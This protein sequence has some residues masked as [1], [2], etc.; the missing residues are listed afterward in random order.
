LKHLKAGKSHW[1]VNQHLITNA[2]VSGQFFYLNTGLPQ[3]K[4][5][6]AAKATEY[7]DAKSGREQMEL[8]RYPSRVMPR[9]S[10]KVF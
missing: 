5:A 8:V 9:D 7:D 4:D 3:A 1:L 6:A 2:T 10:L